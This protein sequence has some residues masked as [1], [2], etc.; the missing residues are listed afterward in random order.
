MTIMSASA[1][2]PLARASAAPPLDLK[3]RATAAALQAKDA[4]GDNASADKK[5]EL[6]KAA[7]SF[8]AIFLRQMIG[9]MRSATGGDTLLGSSASDQFR[10]M[11][12]ARLADDMADKQSFGIAEMVLKQF[13]VD[14]P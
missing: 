12:D 8:E 11:M 7:E 13:G 14:K 3:A 10:D 9:A 2:F 4:A 5:A 1:A 6:T